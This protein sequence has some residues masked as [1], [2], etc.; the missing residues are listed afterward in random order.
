MYVARA[1]A[2]PKHSDNLPRPLQIEGREREPEVE[3]QITRLLD[4]PSDSLWRQAQQSDHHAD[5][6]IQEETLVYFLRQYQRRNDPDTAWKL[7]EILMERSSKFIRRQIAC[8]KSLTQDNQDECIRDVTEQM[9]LDLFNDGPNCEFWEIRFWLCLKRRILNRVQKYR[10]QRE[11]EVPSVMTD[12]EDN[13][14]E[15]DRDRRF[16]DTATLSPQMRAEINAAL[17]ILKEN[18]RTAFVLFYYEEW[19]Q[20]EIARRLGVTDR[21]VRNLLMKAEERLKKWRD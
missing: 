10:R 2:M 17:A 5:G 12:N 13:A 7:A 6:W 18:E 3:T 8:W 20:Q 4:C 11:F 16:A 21:T 19:P 9:I 1:Y 14:Y 15:A